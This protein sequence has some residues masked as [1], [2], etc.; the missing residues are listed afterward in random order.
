MIVRIFYIVILLVTVSVPL[1]SQSE[2]SSHN[3]AL[4]IGLGVGTAT[5]DDGNSDPDLA[6]PLKPWTYYNHY[7]I[8]FILGSRP[9][10]SGYGVNSALSNIRIAVS[11]SYIANEYERQ[12]NPDLMAT[13]GVEEQGDS[14]V[15]GIVDFR[16][17]V[18][19][20]IY[21]DLR[22]FDGFYPYVGIG[23]GATKADIRNL[24]TDITRS[25]LGNSYHTEDSGKLQPLYK[26]MLGMQYDTFLSSG[27]IFFEYTFML[28]PKVSLSPRNNGIVDCDLIEDTTAVDVCNGDDNS[29]N[30]QQFFTK[31]FSYTM[32]MFR[33]G[34]IYRL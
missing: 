30:V 16:H 33:F 20:N 23:A 12:S 29:K 5:M 31:D 25:G 4:Y 34:F 28:I 1:F 9:W 7:N 27:S 8:E 18:T 21:Y 6:T 2:Y 13:F 14:A 32:H 22:Y 15:V 26:A 17:L 3:G 19:G 24:D 11:Y 10:Y